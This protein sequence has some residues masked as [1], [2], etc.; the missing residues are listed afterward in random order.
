MRRVPGPL[1]VALANGLASEGDLSARL[2]DSLANGLACEAY[3]AAAVLIEL[4]NWPVSLNPT[5]HGASTDETQH[6]TYP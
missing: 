6:R 3:A 5:S 1:V 2:A 4:T